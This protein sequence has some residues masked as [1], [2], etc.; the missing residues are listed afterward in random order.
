V[1]RKAG[2]HW[3][4]KRVELNAMTP[5]KLI[6]Y[7]NGQLQANGVRAKVIPPP[8]LLP[9]ETNRIY[10][11]VVAREVEQSLARLLDTADIGRAVAAQF[12]DRIDLGHSGDWIHQAFTND[13]TL[14][15]NGAVK[16]QLHQWLQG[17]VV[18][19]DASVRQAI[20]AIL[21]ESPP[22]RKEYVRRQR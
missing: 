12:R 13:V 21:A 16:N 6:E 11:Q 14:S 8:D 17:E 22:P 10:H 15:W 3:I 19:L 7:I 20:V 4:A 1:G 18:A 5:T 9:T 2:K